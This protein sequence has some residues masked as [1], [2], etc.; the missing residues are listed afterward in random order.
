MTDDFDGN[1]PFD[2]DHDDL[3]D[4]ALNAAGFDPTA[5]VL[6]N[7]DPEAERDAAAR[8]QA[9]DNM[10]IDQ[11]LALE[12]YATGS[13]PAPADQGEGAASFEAHQAQKERDAFLA[14]AR[15]GMAQIEAAR[16]ETREHAQALI[17]ASA[18]SAQDAQLADIERDVA[19][20]SEEAMTD[21]QFAQVLRYQETGQWGAAT[22]PDAQ[23]KRLADKALGVTE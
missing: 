7:P 6:S 19:D 2:P 22:L 11:L 13:E 1:E 15:D 23:L 21:E 12:A 9:I 18:K 8:I 20:F 14:F 3:F 17:R 4:D 5:P 16:A 10:N